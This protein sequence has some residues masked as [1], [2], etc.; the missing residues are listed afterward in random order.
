ME[1]KI[2]TTE[3]P[4]VVVIEKQMTFSHLPI[5][6]QSPPQSPSPQQPANPPPASKK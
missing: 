3:A 2:I 1:R 4:R 6:P 5:A